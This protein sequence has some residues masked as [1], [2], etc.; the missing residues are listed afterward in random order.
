MKDF[1]KTILLL[2]AILILSLLAGCQEKENTSQ[3]VAAEKAESLQSKPASKVAEAATVSK[4]K[5]AQGKAMIEFE[6]NVVNLGKLSPKD[7]AKG[8]FKFKNTGT[9]N[10]QIKRIK[11]TCGCT[12]V[13]QAKMKKNY[14]PGE[15]GSFDIT[16]TADL[17]PGPITKNL[18]V[19][20]N[21]V[22]KPA[23]VCRLKANIVV[24]VS[25]DPERF[26][27]SFKEENAGM[28]PITLKSTDGVAFKIVSF[29][30]T[31]ETVKVDFDPNK[32][33]LEFVLQPTVDLTKFNQDRLGGIIDIKLS[34]P[35]AKSL[36]I[37]Y[38][39][40]P[41]WVTTPAKFIIIDAEYGTVSKR[42]LFIKSNYGEKVEVASVSSQEK[43]MTV[44]SQLQEGNG[45]RMKVDIQVPTKDKMT[46]IAKKDVLE[47]K[48]ETGDTLKVECAIYP[49]RK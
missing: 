18:T 25:K 13:D 9:A 12:V 49:K 26:Q 33:A 20:S 45:V 32:E 1:G 44:V 16:Y 47:I 4:Q 22:G 6:S 14:E 28:G 35:K 21:S 31:D 43:L 10:L 36:R 38:S 8:T 24:A 39:I 7:K 37:S 19:Y 40:K 11:S 34:H 46:Q 48:L 30:S 5:P 15:S 42:N 3:A 41:M 23:Y 29:T 17:K 27:L 2:S